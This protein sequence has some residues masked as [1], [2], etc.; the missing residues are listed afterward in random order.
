[1][2]LLL[3]DANFVLAASFFELAAPSESGLFV[4]I[5]ADAGHCSYVDRRIEM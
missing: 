1:M 4:H 2:L 5:R 3:A